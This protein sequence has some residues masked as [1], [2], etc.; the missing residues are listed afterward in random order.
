MAGTAIRIA[1]K[2]DAELIA[3]ISRLTFFE[4]F[5]AENT[6]ENMNKF[7]SEQ[8]SKEKLMAEVGAPGNI[9][10]LAIDEE[11]PVGYV[12][13]KE[14][15]HNESLGAVPAIEISRIYAM[16]HKIGKGVGPLL[17]QACIDMAKKMNKKIIWLAVW[18]KNQKGI[19]F[20]KKWGFERFGEHDF[21]LGDDVQ[22]D[23]LMKKDLSQ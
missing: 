3:N 12:R 23:W 6:K 14:T 10:L 16:P 1:N 11:G 21:I 20:Y 22:L 17:M 2:E 15:E 9:F 13:M 7:M 18:E 8:F 4:T 5:A 19:S